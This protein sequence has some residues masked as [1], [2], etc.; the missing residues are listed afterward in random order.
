MS[1][2][3]RL[4][5]GA[6]AGIAGGAALVAVVSLVA[7][8][9]GFGRQLVYQGAVG[10]T[11]LGTV[12]TSS[13]F[14]PAI[15]FEVV[16][17]GALA[18]VVVPLVVAA[19]ERRDTAE[20][21]E[22]T[23]ALIGWAL[24]V[25]VPIA[26][27]GAL[28]AGP[29]SSYMLQGQGGAQAQDMAERMLRVFLVQVPLYGLAAVSAGVLQAHRR[30]FAPALAPIVSS[31]VVASTYLV[32]GA[33]FTGHRNDLG[34]VPRSAEVLLS[35][36]TA[37]G[38][39]ALAMTTLVPLYLL[40]VRA[41]PRLRFPAGRG[42]RAARLAAAGATMVAAQQMALLVLIPVVN[43]YGGAGRIV[44]YQNSW[45]VY[46]LPYA[47]LAVP[48]AT[49]SFP[50]LAGHAS[51]GDQLEWART[52]LGSTRAVVLAAGL[53]VAALIAAAWP[54]ARFFG[55]IGDHGT[56]PDAEMARAL[57]AFAP[58]LIGFCLVYHLNRAL[59]AIGRVRRVGA[60]TT[61]GWAMAVVVA[62][63]LAS[64]VGQ[65]WVV[66]AVGLGHTAGMAVAA[67][68]LLVALRSGSAGA[69]WRR[70][71]RAGLAAVAGAGAGAVAGFAAA[72]VLD[73][74]GTAAT[75]GT[76]VLAAAVATVVFVGVVALVDYDDLRAVLRR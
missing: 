60:A 30:F 55:V 66:A 53:G 57:V 67:G 36:G 11:E 74:V 7:R 43:E 73:S 41:V 13:N 22:A 4:A 1:H 29:I 50:T 20:L 26:I 27:A 65:D 40:G 39:V 46:L 58:G 45:M 10:P 12:Y 51:R 14:V 9:V 69:G 32:F 37:L 75:V 23:G 76:G 19:V 24:V 25:L 3:G 47:V 54:I 15:L 72:G 34:T 17:G 38:A 61:V 35:V 48:I 21:R 6:A 52:T 16:A 68:L 59:L 33:T 8:L 49:S 42:R 71:A 63:V 18:G 64:A 31:V 28:L 5:L 70:L 44:T 2:G 62:V 56:V